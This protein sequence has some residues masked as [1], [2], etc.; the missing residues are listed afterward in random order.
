MSA[1]GL[2]T[3]LIVGAYLLGS[4]PFALIIAR[5]HGV[6]IRKVGSGNVGATNVMRTLGRGP[7]LLCFALDFLK[8]LA[9]VL[10]AGIV[11]GAVNNRAIP[12]AEAWLWLA[13][14]AA[15]ILGHIFP[16][17]AGF[18]GGKGVA[19][20]FGAMLA[21]WPQMGAPALAA[22]ALWVVCQR[23]TRNVGLSSS[24]AAVFIPLAVLGM[25]LA[26]RPGDDAIGWPFV[27]V[28]GLLGGLVV[29][30][31]ATNLSRTFASWRGAGGP[32]GEARERK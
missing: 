19:T 24:I 2:W 23:L 13:V 17:W 1:A 6:D 29:W 20:S 12:P 31:H 18:R 16:V 21:V 30:R 14:A 11:T 9:P 28:A 22:F 3:V 5:A 27:I 26:W 10:A 32:K 8:G 4:V 7:G 15:A 25:Q